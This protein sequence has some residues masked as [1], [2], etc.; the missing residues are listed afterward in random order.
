MPRG[1]AQLH[2]S[3]T[4]CSSFFAHAIQHTHVGREV[5]GVH[6]TQD[7]P[8]V[9]Q[10]LVLQICYA[11]FRPPMIALAT[12]SNPRLC[13]DCQGRHRRQFP[14]IEPPSELLVGSVWDARLFLSSCESNQLCAHP[15]WMQL[16]FSHMLYANLQCA[17][18]FCSVMHGII[19]RRSAM[20]LSVRV[21]L[22]TASS[23]D[24]R[25]WH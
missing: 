8:C 3:Q 1:S 5:G 12:C 18:L 10:P 11:A 16:W 7:L 15:G 23:L 9:V 21:W 24:T 6:I 2:P 4:M 19:L 20:A 14:C 17:A 25:R 22:S 13:S